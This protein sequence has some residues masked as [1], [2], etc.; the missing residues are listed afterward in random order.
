MAKT[1]NEWPFRDR[2]R[3]GEWLANHLVRFR[4][5][6]PILL[7]IPRGGVEVA[8]AIADRFGL[9]L[10]VIVAR[11]IGAP[12]QPELAIGAATA[13]GGLYLDHATIESIGTD[14]RYL[15]S[16]IERERAEA[17]RRE[18]EYRGE[19]PPL[20]LSGRTVI[21]IDDGLATGATARAAARAVRKRSPGRLVLTAPV[22]S[23]EAIASLGDE[24]D[25][26]V[27]PLAP[28]FFWAVGGYY[29]DFAQLEDADVTRLLREYARLR[30]RES[31]VEA[32]E[33]GMLGR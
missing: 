6:N 24:V 16:T 10:D 23:R 22:G 8:A 2:Y 15:T 19:R 20:D 28:E 11:K 26:V 25:E 14:E 27:C 1:Q 32:S 4:D 3:A 31:G 33:P 13:N 7:G 30:A 18:R 5:A 29:I 17:Q 9:E 21:L 12:D